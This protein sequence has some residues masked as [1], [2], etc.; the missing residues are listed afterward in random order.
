MPS[1]KN[2]VQ[3][4]ESLPVFPRGWVLPSWVSAD[5]DALTSAFYL[6]CLTPPPRETARDLASASS[7]ESEAL[8]SQRCA[9]KDPRPTRVPAGE[10]P[11]CLA[12]REC[13]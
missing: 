1:K 12:R 8:T 7:S 5:L 10:A 13:P 2:E 9:K 4:A 3:H 11:R 6:P